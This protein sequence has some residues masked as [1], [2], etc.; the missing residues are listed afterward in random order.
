MTIFRTVILTAIIF[1]V[2]VIVLTILDFA[3]LH[4]IRRD[5]VSPHVLEHLEIDIAGKLPHWTAT[6]GEW[7]AISLSFLLR[8]IFLVLNIMVLAYI[9]RKADLNREFS[10]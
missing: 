6:E 7:R 4:D 3:A 8:S 9:Y 2:L 5:Y 1:G 10:R